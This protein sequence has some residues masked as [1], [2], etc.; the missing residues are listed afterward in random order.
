MTPNHSASAIVDGAVERSR[1]H[2]FDI[3]DCCVSWY[4]CLALVSLVSL[5]GK[6]DECSAPRLSLG[7]TRSE[8][9]RQRE[10][11]G[12][13]M[14]VNNA[15]AVTVAASLCCSI[16]VHCSAV[17]AIDRPLHPLFDMTSIVA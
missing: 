16:M 6:E 2:Q 12:H 13:K 10:K 4:R 9:S 8:T 3:Y 11:D 7:D 17:I 14:S 1:S 15:F 5:F